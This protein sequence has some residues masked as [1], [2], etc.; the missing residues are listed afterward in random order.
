M[1]FDWSGFLDLAAE[2]AARTDEAAHRSAISRAYY[3]ALGK[4]RELLEHEGEAFTSTE[5]IHYLVWQTLSDSADD[6]RYYIGVDGNWLRRNRNAADYESV[7]TD[8]KER[9]A[10]SVRKARALLAAL[11]RVRS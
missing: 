9:A 10:Q 2:L 1:A 3:A 6:R 11:E 5:N 4:A 8:S 7:L